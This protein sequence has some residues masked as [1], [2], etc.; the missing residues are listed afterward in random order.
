[1]ASREVG[2]GHLLEKSRNKTGF[3]GR[4]VSWIRL[5]S[6]G[7]KVKWNCLWAMLESEGQRMRNMFWNSL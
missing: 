5:A 6:C 3:A 4:M 1:M 7:G 2:G